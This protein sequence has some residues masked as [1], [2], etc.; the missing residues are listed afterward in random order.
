MHGPDMHPGRIVIDDRPSDEVFQEL[1]DMAVRA[2]PDA[3]AASLLL[4]DPTGAR[5]AVVRSRP[6]ESDGSDPATVE[7]LGDRYDANTLIS[8]ASSTSETVSWPLEV[9]GDREGRLIIWPSHR[10]R[11]GETAAE[12]EHFVAEA[13]ALVQNM[14]AVED[15]RTA[16]KQLTDGIRSRE[17]IGLAKG[18]LMH[19][20]S[21]SER[22]AFRILVTASQRLNRKVR[23]VA[24]DVVAL[25][26]GRARLS[27]TSD[28]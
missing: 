15:L 22:A 4:D 21:C 2:I 3:N 25:A 5:R 24:A 28:G 6:S 18:I 13:G 19:Q 23:D 16:K 10:S 27:G 14:L 8:A 7:P 1:V 11:H 26:E 20:E 12:A 9:G 17:T